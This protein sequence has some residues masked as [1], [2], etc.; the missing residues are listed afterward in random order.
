MGGAAIGAGTVCA[1]ASDRRMISTHL[2]GLDGSQPDVCIVG[3]G[4]VG[5][6]LALEL[7]RL[8]RSVLL[9]E[10]GNLKQSADAQEL[11]TASI[12]DPHTHVGM[13]VAVS[14]Q[15][16]GASN[17][18]GGRCVAM[19]EHDFAPRSVVPFSGWPIGLS[20]VA[21]YIESACKYLCCEP[22]AFV[23][24][25]PN[26][27]PANDD[28]RFDRLERWSRAPR[29]AAVYA[30]TLRDT[31]KI[32][33]RMRAVVVGMEHAEDGLLTRLCIRSLDGGEIHCG[34]RCVILAAG[35]LE[36]TR[37]LLATQR[38]YPGSFG[39]E[40]GPL[41]RYYMGHLYGSSAEMVIHS[42]LLDSGIDYYI[43]R[44]GTYVRR[45][46][47][48]SEALQRRM[49]LTNVSF[50]PDYPPIHDPSHRN[51]ILSLAY[52]SLSVPFIGRRIVVES[53]R[54]HYLGSGPL[55]RGPHIL[56]VLRDAL[57]TAAFIPSFVHRRYVARP[58]MP[59]FF[60]RNDSRRYSIRFHAEHLPNPD[61]R[62]TL[63]NDIDALGLPRLNIDFRYTEADAAPLIRAHDCFGQWLEKTGL[64]S[65]SWPVPAAER[66][67]H[68]LAQCYDGHHQIGTTRMASNPRLGVVDA[69]CRVHGVANLFVAGSSVFATSA[70]ANPTM[71][72][73]AL[74]I[75]LAELVARS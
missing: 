51:G 13:D 53:I 46:F 38:R 4:P 41:G 74:G 31:P 20:D 45:R 24:P 27:K 62:V 1:T 40:D 36:N 49:E 10:S 22:A 63:S 26:F 21:P 12:L 3:A 61:S 43:S 65:M 5:I 59:G 55:R 32:D 57:R 28:F 11:A 56:N 73:V 19:E 30:R 44:D 47:T 68:I 39:G 60:Q 7:A 70:E 25:L 34:P 50:W 6:V 75:R 14:R 67:Q 2:Q 18:W 9:L 37:L 48:P 29:I 71:M 42:P 69:D 66:T 54:Q 15:L 35:G 72:A 58:R 17:L 64:G 16:G 23:D 8:G 33:L 52:L